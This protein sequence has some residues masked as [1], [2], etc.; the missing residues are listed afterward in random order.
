[1]WAPDSEAEIHAAIKAGD[2][3]ETSSFDAK[4]ALPTGKKTRDLAI[5]VAAMANDGGTLL[6]GV[7]EDENKMLKVLKPFVLAGTSE[8]VDQIVRTSIAEPPTIEVR[9]IPTTSD[10]SVGYLVVTV[11]PSARAPHMV[12]VN[13]DH[14]FYG[15]GATG[16][17]RL[18]EGEVA[19][20]YERRQR[21]EIDRDV[22][23]D[24]MVQSAPIES[25][26]EFAYL[27]LVIR[28]VTPDEDL[29]DRARGELSA[30]RFF[31]GL[32]SEA[33]KREVYA[34]SYSPDL[35]SNNT[36]ERRAD[37]WATSRGLGGEWWDFEDPSHVIDLEVDLDGR[38]R[39]FCGRAADTHNGRLLVFEAIVAGLTTRFLALMGSLY[40]SGAYFGQV[41]VGLAV[42]N[43][44]DGI[45][46]VLSQR[47]GVHANPYNKDVYRRTARFSAS[48]L[49]EQPRDAARKLVLPLARALSRESYDPFAD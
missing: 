11:P 14:R 20:L 28:P 43:L 45:S 33:L 15:R 2:L 22:M 30:E 23:L 26:E 39:L 48:M 6:Y 24:E 18:T 17:A 29:F 3:N 46:Y 19:R 40:A 4:E 36:Y 38:G 21:W 8:R 16:N 32:I 34:K 13:K 37:G 42:T 25:R 10:S 47:I 1:M 49:R 9:Q 31:Q 5:D 41:D 35:S 12:V 27:H 44:K 7:G